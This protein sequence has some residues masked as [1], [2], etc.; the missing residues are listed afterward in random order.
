MPKLYITLSFALTHSLLS[1][2]TLNR[3]IRM[4]H[5]K[6]KWWDCWKRNAGT[7]LK[8]LSQHGEQ[9]SSTE[10][11]RDRQLTSSEHSKTWS[12]LRLHLDYYRHY[13][14]KLIRSKTWR[15]ELT[16]TL[17]KRGT[18]NRSSLWSK[19]SDGMQSKGKIFL[20][21]IS[22]V[23]ALRMI[24]LIKSYKHWDS[25]LSTYSPIT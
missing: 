9:S 12:S 8:R 25:T 17:R 23:N 21:N 7:S 6:P 1:I 16:T 15:E 10:S 14:S 2:S 22:L 24:V 19:L 4:L 5:S 20:D 18:T 13:V 3:L 11:I